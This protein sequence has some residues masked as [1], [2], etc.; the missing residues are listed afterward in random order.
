MSDR[1]DLRTR[2]SRQQLLLRAVPLA[3]T[4]LFLVLVATTGRSFP[5]VFVL[6]VVGLA[7]LVALLPDS[8]AGVFL[9]LALA[10]L[11][12]TTVPERLDAV[13]LVA[14]ADLLALHVAVALAATGPPGLVLPRSLLLAW[15][16]R[17]LGLLAL[18]LAAWVVARLVAGADVRPT[19][20]GM[21]TGLG[22][23]LGWGALLTVRLDTGDP[24]AAG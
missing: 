18:A 7:V 13:V 8:S 23:L 3:A 10:G 11:W 22:L 24:D 1:P 19:A 16:G 15:A 20:V 5:L 9:V 2:L 4:A 21:A 12:G 14:A 17:F 6:P